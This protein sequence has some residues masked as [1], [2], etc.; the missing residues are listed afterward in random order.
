[1]TIPVSALTRLA[2]LGLSSEQAEAVALM[3]A[4]VEEA[5]ATTVKAEADRAIEAGRE[6]GRARWKR[7]DEKRK[8]NVSPRLPTTAN[9]SKQLA[10]GDARVEDK[11]SNSEIEPH[12]ENKKRASAKVSELDAFKA[13]L[14]LDIDAEQMAALIE[15]RRRKRAAL[16]AKA[17]RMFRDDATKCGLSVAEAADTCIRRNWITVEPDWLAKPS[18]AGPAAKSGG[19][20]AAFGELDRYLNGQGMGG[21]GGEAPTGVVLSLPHRRAQ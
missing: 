19:L 4:E 3:L 1:M 18:R 15:H 21:D 6:K 16:T 8:S 14:S 5:T 13:E 9:G 12:E 2:G 17:A 11:T 7:W 10:G 20:G